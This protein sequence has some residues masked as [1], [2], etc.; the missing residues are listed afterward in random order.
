[1][2]FHLIEFVFYSKGD[3]LLLYYD[4]AWGLEQTGVWTGGKMIRFLIKVKL[5]FSLKLYIYIIKV[6]VTWQNLTIKWKNG[7]KF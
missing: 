2:D 6:K 7:I 4:G 1:M 3:G 5:I